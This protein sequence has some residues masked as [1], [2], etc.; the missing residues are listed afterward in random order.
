LSLKALLL[1]PGPST[2]LYKLLGIFSGIFR[3]A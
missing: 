3:G 2:N 1:V